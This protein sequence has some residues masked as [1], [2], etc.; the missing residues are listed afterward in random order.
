MAGDTSLSP[1]LRIMERNGFVKVHGGGIR[2]KRRVVTLTAQ[3][4]AALAIGGLPV[5]ATI[6]AGPLSENL[7]QA[8]TI[9]DEA[10]VLPYR[11][12][13][14][15]LVVESDSMIGD[16]ILPGDKV[17]LRPNVEPRNGEIAAIQWGD[18]YRAT[19]KHVRFTS[20][21]RRIILEASNPNFHS[22]TLSASDVR[23][24]GVYRG[25]VRVI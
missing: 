4:K 25:L 23:I 15:L 5:L 21:R 13:D 12:G 7:S 17:L 6:P 22:L 20:G 11:P 9:L 10:E 24:A 19:L 16:G 1:T 14:F 2:G 18:D 8:D 3:A